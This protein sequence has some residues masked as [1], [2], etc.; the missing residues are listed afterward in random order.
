MPPLHLVKMPAAND[1]VI[2]FLLHGQDSK[3]ASMSTY[4]PG[5]RNPSRSPR[6]QQAQKLIE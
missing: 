1:A 2:A 6:F 3:A 4:K 5:G